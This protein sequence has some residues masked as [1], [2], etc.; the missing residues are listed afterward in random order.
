MTTD[1]ASLNR[2]ENAIPTGRDEVIAAIL[3]SARQ[4]FAGR[5]L[6]A[7]SIRDIETRPGSTTVSPFGTSA[8]KSNSCLP[9]SIIWPTT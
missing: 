4:M 9:C 7:A 6:A 8:P 1:S 3:D 5:G 2:V